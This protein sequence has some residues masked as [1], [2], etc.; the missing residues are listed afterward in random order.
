MIAGGGG[1]RHPEDFY[2][3]PRE[4][5]L[6]LLYAYGHLIG[7]V[8]HEPSCGTGA[9]ASV[10]IE[11]G[12]QVIAT[13]LVDRGYGQGG[14]DYLK[15]RNRAS[16]V[17]TNPPFKHAAAFIEHGVSQ[18]P[19]FFA[20]L[21]KATFWNAAARVKLY[22]RFP[23]KLTLPLTWRLDFTNQGSPTMDCTWFVWG[24]AIPMPQPPKLLRKPK[25]VEQGVFA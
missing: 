25:V 3:T 8:V 20:L 22:E 10:L 6:A 1:K 9:M 16:S 19:V 17:L 12:Y 24:S 18:D 2:A 14:I 4:A 21:L 13:D 11:H 7:P 5:T 23:P 15:D